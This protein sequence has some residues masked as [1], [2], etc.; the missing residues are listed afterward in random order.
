ML[1]SE[2]NIDT[3]E[4]CIALNPPGV[5]LINTFKGN[6]CFEMLWE[7]VWVTLVSIDQWYKLQIYACLIIT[8]FVV[9]IDR[10]CRFCDAFIQKL[11]N[12]CIVEYVLL[13]IEIIFL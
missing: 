13:F 5:I 4:L 1:S 12:K 10:I 8:K 9:R 3:S 6:L 11:L 7:H 2:T